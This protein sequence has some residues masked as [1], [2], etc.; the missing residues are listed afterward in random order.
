LIG[1]RAGQFIVWE[2]AATG[3]EIRAVALP[4]VVQTR[5]PRVSPDGRYVA[6]WIE[7][8]RGVLRD[9]TTGQRVFDMPQ[10]TTDA[11]FS[12]DGKSVAMLTS[13]IGLR[14]IDLATWAERP[15]I[16]TWPFA[17]VWSRDSRRIAFIYKS[18]PPTLAVVDAATMKIEGTL[19]GQGLPNIL[20]A[21][22]PDGRTLVS[23]TRDGTLRFWNL[24]T[25][26]RTL[27]LP[28]E[29]QIGSLVFAPGGEALMLSRGGGWRQ[30]DAPFR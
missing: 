18:N 24:Q 3:A 23:N 6:Y 1:L 27:V 5:L 19:T 7:L 26:S 14:V 10:G 9:L 13:G 2:D 22:S 8:N 29:G 4:K 25:W 12:P 16:S 21:F 28:P 17:L 20:L 30:I 11:Q 15:P